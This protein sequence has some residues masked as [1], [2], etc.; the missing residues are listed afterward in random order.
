M[1]NQIALSLNDWELDLLEEHSSVIYSTQPAVWGGLHTE[2][3]KFHNDTVANCFTLYAAL[4]VALFSLARQLAE[5]LKDDDE[6]SWPVLRG[7]I[8]ESFE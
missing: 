2:T 3:M 7:A 1:L 5:E 6:S 4:R 8:G